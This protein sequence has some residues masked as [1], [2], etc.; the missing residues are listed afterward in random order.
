MWKSR[1][2]NVERF[3]AEQEEVRATENFGNINS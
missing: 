2:N 3:S 1:Q